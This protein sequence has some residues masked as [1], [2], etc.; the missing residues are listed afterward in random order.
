MTKITNKLTPSTTDIIVLREQ[1]TSSSSDSIFTD[2][3]TTPIGFATEINQCYYSEENVC[4]TSDVDKLDQLAGETVPSR[5]YS[6]KTKSNSDILNKLSKLSLTNVDCYTTAPNYCSETLLDTSDELDTTMSLANNIQ[7]V[8]RMSP[9][10]IENCTD[11]MNIFNVARVK[12]VELAKVGNDSVSATIN[13]AQLIPT[14]L[15]Q[16]SITP[17][18]PSSILAPSVCSPTS[19]G[20]GNVLKK[21]ASFTVERTNSDNTASKIS[22]PSY[23]P[24]K[25]N[26]GAYEKF[27]G[28][29]LLNWMSSSSQPLYN[30]SDQD[31]SS[32]L[33]QQYCTNLLVAGVIKQIPDKYA[34][35]QETFRQKKI[36]TNLCFVSEKCSDIADCVPI[37]ITQSSVACNVKVVK[38]NECNWGQSSQR[39]I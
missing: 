9:S 29:M 19:Q 32:L 13:E 7:K 11:K 36:S 15:Q 38:L 22:R 28:Q 14:I 34:P 4:D 3:L 18:T 24:E 39:A 23:V 35:I 30:V 16:P 2:P 12:K 5:I 31:I 1:T 17:P 21:V 20:D 27:E 6:R 25:L 26:F 10:N 37:N 8:N 33:I